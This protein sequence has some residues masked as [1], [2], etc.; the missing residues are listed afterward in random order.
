MKEGVYQSG[1]Q[2][3][4]HAKGGRSATMQFDPGRGDEFEMLRKHVLPGSWGDGRRQ[5]QQQ[6]HRYA[7]QGG[8]EAPC[9]LLVHLGT[10]RDTCE[11]YSVHIR[12]ARSH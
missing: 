11:T 9:T 6:T 1:E 2:S 12:A 5:L 7:L 10:R 3:P 8:F 4:V